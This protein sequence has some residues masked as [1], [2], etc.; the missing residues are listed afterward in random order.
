MRQAGAT[1]QAAA[2]FVA[3]EALTNSAKHA[4]A[5]RA[6]VA[7]TVTDGVLRLEVADDGRGGAQ[8]TPGGG[9]E[10]LRSRVLALDG[11]FELD[12]PAGGGTRLIVEVPC[13]S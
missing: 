1:T 6:R 7:V 8:L 13:A 10:G 12:S 3:T 5:T 4:H 9:L 2:Y 11:T